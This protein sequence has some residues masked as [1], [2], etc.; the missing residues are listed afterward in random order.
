MDARDERII[1]NS[2]ET[3]RG[4]ARSGAG[5][6]RKRVRCFANSQLGGLFSIHAGTFWLYLSFSSDS[7]LV[8]RYN[9]ADIIL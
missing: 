5:C 2:E 8:T 7:V 9:A 1:S 3:W 6:E 4:M